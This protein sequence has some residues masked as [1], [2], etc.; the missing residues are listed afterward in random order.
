M[1]EE[2]FVEKVGF[3]NVQV[4]KAQLA[5][6]FGGAGL[7]ARIAENPF[8]FFVLPSGAGFAHHLVEKG[9]LETSDQ[10]ELFDAFGR[11][12]RYWLYGRALYRTEAAEPALLTL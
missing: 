4:F 1:A 11:E 5:D 10:K 9:I 12:V 7:P 8:P 6:A 3:D 2:H